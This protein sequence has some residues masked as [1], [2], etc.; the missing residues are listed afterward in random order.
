MLFQ[1]N[2]GAAK[3]VLAKYLIETSR[4]EAKYFS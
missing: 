1:G 3:Q 4:V 2:Q